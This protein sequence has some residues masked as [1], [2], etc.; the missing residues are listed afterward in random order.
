MEEKK[1]RQNLDACRW[2]TLSLVEQLGNIG[3]EIGRAINAQKQGKEEKKG[4]ALDMAFEL[5]DLTISDSRWMARLK[6]LT[7]SREVV[8]DYFFGDNVYNSA[9]ENLE[10]YFYWFAF[11][12]RKNR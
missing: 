10:K 3:S 12:A 5:F 1:Q 2:Q 9:P 6:E 4:H 11:A 7:R 8:A